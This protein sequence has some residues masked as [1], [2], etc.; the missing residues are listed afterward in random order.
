MIDRNELGIYLNDHLAGATGGVELARRAAHGSTRHREA[1][2]A[3]ATELAEDRSALRQIMRTLGIPARHYKQYGA[4]A[5]EKI[6]RLKLNGQL[7]GRAPLSDVLE[8]EGLRLAVEGKAARW[9]LL[10]RLAEHDHRLDRDLLD[11]LLTRAERQRQ[12]LDELHMSAATD[13]FAP[14]PGG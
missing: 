6:G 14:R 13:V 1:L 3:I 10:R 5:A 8:I 7:T 9:R 12:V 2:H 11:R 4:W